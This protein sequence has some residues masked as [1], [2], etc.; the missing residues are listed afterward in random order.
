MFSV[1]HAVKFHSVVISFHTCYLLITEKICLSLRKD[2]PLAIF[3]TLL[4][5]NVPSVKVLPKE[6]LTL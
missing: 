3:K 5:A 4:I 1:T 6:K 2:S